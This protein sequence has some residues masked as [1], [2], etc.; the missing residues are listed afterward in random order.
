MRFLHACE[1]SQVDVGVTKLGGVELSLGF[2]QWNRAAEVSSPA[3]C[4]RRENPSIVKIERHEIS[5]PQAATHDKLVPFG[6]EPSVLQVAVVLI[7]PE[8]RNLAVR[9]VLAQHVPGRSWTLLQCVLPV[10][11]ADV[12]PE[13]GMVVV[14]HITSRVDPLHA[15]SEVLIDHDAIVDLHTGAGE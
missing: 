13:H 5:L 11:D 10:L 15:R 7:G 3:Y 1:R 6:V 2:D 14:G 12:T 9:L 8:P 4:Y